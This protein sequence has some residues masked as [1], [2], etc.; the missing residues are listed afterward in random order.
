MGYPLGKPLNRPPEGP[1][2]FP[3]PGRPNWWRKTPDGEPFYI[4][5]VKPKP[6]AEFCFINWGGHCNCPSGVTP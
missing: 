6:H 5:P 4:E 1:K 3:V 2:L